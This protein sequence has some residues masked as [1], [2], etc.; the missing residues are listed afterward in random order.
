MF[1]GI[2][3]QTC[4]VLHEYDRKACR[5]DKKGQKKKDTIQPFKEKSVL[6]LPET[7]YCIDDLSR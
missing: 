2:R 6:Q 4:F 5:G 7:W 3:R 1:R